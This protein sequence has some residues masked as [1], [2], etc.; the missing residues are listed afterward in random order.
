LC[1]LPDHL[2]VVAE[3]RADDSHL[4]SFAKLAKQYSGYYYRDKATGRLW[5]D[6]YYDHV[7]RDNETTVKVVRYVLENPV[8]ARLASTV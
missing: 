1:V 2:H 3:G 4:P 5:Q 8:R 7:L 6:G